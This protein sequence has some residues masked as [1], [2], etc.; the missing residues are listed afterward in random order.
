MKKLSL[1][2][3]LALVISIG[4]VYATWFYAT[5]SV[6][7]VNHKFKGLSITDV[8]T[9][10]ESGSF[11]I[12]DTLSLKIDDN[13]GSHTPAWDVDV[14]GADAGT[15]GIT[16]TPNS[17]AP[18]TTLQYSIIISNNS[19]TPAGGEAMPIF[20]TKPGAANQIT[21]A[22]SNEIVVL[23]GTFVYDPAISTNP[24]GKT[25][26]LEDIQAV[27]DVNDEINLPQLSD[28]QNFNKALIGDGTNSYP[29][30]GFVLR[31]EEV[32]P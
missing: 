25:I 5:T 15:V 17:G 21:E 18:L 32:T 1:I 11:S 31:I 4:G 19:Y 9:K 10:T 30:V 7:T 6:T 28:Y 24:V 29:G 22:H 20:V 23:Q 16:F 8:D 14:T 13:D 27:L 12:T 2:V 3:A 26:R